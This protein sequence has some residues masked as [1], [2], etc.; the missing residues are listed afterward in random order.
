MRLFAGL[1]SD[2]AQPAHLLELRPRSY[3]LRNMATPNSTT[4]NASLLRALPSVDQLLRTSEAISLRDK[5]GAARITILARAIT[6]DLRREIQETPTG[7]RNFQSGTPARAALLAEAVRRLEAV[8]QQERRKGVRR[9][10]NATGVIIHTNLGRAPL[11][12]DA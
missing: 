1:E 8:D 12:A 7:A 6:D 11:A 2:R 9:V 4:A 5:V 3:A 10:I